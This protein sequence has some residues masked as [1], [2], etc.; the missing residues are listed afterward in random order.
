VAATATVLKVVDGDTVD[1][2]DDD[3][4]A[5]WCDPLAGGELVCGVLAPS[6]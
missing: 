4:G 2:V 6:A 5:R 1:I 3:Q